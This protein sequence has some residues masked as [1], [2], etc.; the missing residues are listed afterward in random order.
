MIFTHKPLSMDILSCFRIYTSVCVEL[1][2]TL[3]FSEF[4]ISAVF[5]QYLWVADKNRSGKAIA[6]RV[7]FQLSFTSVL[8]VCVIISWGSTC[9]ST[10]LN[11]Y[12][13][14]VKSLWFEKISQI[15]QNINFA[16]AKLRSLQGK[17]LFSKISFRSKIQTW[18]PRN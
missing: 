10:Y 12:F 5:I 11:S 15:C 2:T 7:I 8:I 13:F 4:E 3:R 17:I 1:R 9:L 16:S 18:L 14:I 6:T